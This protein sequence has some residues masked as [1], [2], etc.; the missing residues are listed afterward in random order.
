MVGI[1]NYISQLFSTTPDG[2]IFLALAVIWGFFGAYW[3]FAFFYDI[4]TG[5]GKPKLKSGGSLVHEIVPRLLIVLAVVGIVVTGSRSLL[6]ERLIPGPN[7]ISFVGVGIAVFG[8]LFAIWARNYLGGN[9]GATIG[10]KKGHTLV[11]TGPYA[12]VRH[13]IYT[14][15]GFG[16]AGSAIALGNTFGIVVLL[17]VLLFLFFRMGDEEKIMVEKFG[18]EYK[19]YEKKVRK[20]IPFLY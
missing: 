17:G 7:I 9:W 10:L 16:M 11:R 4:I 18:K 6:V 19:E 15:I 1:V 20:F 14:G 12:I 5:R 3:A 13:P 2:S 8:A